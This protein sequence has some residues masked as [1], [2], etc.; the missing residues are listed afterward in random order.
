M[1]DDSM[2]YF[3]DSSTKFNNK[4]DDTKSLMHETG[5]SSFEQPTGTGSRRKS[6][7]YRA[8]FLKKTKKN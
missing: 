1:F 3:F 5:T 2:R 7:R 8:S 6:K 4:D